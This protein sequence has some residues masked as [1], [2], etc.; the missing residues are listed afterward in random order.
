MLLI[1]QNLVKFVTED[2][3]SLSPQNVHWNEAF[4]EQVIQS[5]TTSC[6]IVV[7]GRN[8][9]SCEKELQCGPYRTAG[10]SL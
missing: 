4:K 9:Q 10:A 7:M 8:R 1:M 3:T 2:S 6:P 5:V